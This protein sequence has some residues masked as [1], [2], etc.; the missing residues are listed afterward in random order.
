MINL[1]IDRERLDKMLALSD[2][3]LW[4]EIRSIC[5]R[6]KLSV[7]KETPPHEKLESLRE[8]ARSGRLSFSD[9]MR[10]LKDYKSRTEG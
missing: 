7:P 1:K 4:G 3:E 2:D 6:V 10:M 8:I 9:A 5:D